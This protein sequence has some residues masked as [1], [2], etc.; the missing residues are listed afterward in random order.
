MPTG[1]S[2]S[3][4]LGD[5]RQH[6]GVLLSDV[7]YTSSSHTY[8]IVLRIQ[9]V[10]EVLTAHPRQGVLAQDQEMTSL[11]RESIQGNPLAESVYGVNPCAHQMILERVYKIHFG[12]GF[13]KVDYPRNFVYPSDTFSKVLISAK[14]KI[15]LDSCV[16]AFLILIWFRC[17]RFHLQAVLAI[18]HCNTSESSSI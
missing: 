3:T 15:A 1:G 13:W 2:E 8:K 14:V 11:D 18:S 17:G 9:N 7:V 6:L 16:I 5:L 12:Y 4:L 10:K